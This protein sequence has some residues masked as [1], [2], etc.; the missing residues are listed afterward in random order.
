MHALFGLLTVS[1]L[2]VGEAV[3]LARTDV[4]LDSGIITIRHAKHDRERL[5]PLHPTTTTA[6]RLYA[7]ER[8]RLC[9][10]PR[11][12]TFFLSSTGGTLNRSE[13]DKAFRAITTA[14]GLRTSTTRPVVHDLR[15]RFAVQTLIRWTQAGTGVDANI[16]LLSTYLGH[17]APSDTYWYLQAV[18]ELLELAAQRLDTTPRGGP[19]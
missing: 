11:A 10:R 1:G 13:V 17:I 5:V 6:L 12:Q 14:I 16:A 3:A 7:A 19:R 15:H 2:R 9:P 18:P 4:D 8:D